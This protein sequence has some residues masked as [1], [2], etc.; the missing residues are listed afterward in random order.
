MQGGAARR[1]GR[2]P[3]F[4]LVGLGS[5]AANPILEEEIFGCLLPPLTQFG[6]PRFFGCL[7]P[8]IT[9][10]FADEIFGYL[11]PPTALFS[12]GKNSVQFAFKPF[13]DLASARSLRLLFLVRDSWRRG[14]GLCKAELL[15]EGVAPRPLFWL[16]SARVRRTPFWKRRILECLLPPTTHFFCG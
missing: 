6:R 15:G 5:G 10:F 13:K 7:L 3:T 11:L 2:S 4:A 8:P 12:R 1:R 9:H 16:A 14:S